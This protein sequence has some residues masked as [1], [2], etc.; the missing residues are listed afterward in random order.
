MASYLDL[1]KR[2]H[3][4][5]LLEV[6]VQYNVQEKSGNRDMIPKLPA[7]IVKHPSEYWSISYKRIF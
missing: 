3:K 7:I 5:R 1:N 2:K 4:L 6:Y